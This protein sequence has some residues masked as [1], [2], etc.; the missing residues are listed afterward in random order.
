[1]TGSMSPRA[2][3]ETLISSPPGACV[4]STASTSAAAS[5]D[6]RSASGA[7][8]VRVALIRRTLA[9]LSDATDP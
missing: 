1:M 7:V 3:A 6:V 5:S 8:P 4:T 2:V 9:I